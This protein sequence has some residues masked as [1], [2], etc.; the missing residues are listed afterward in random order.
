MRGLAMAILRGFP[1]T[2]S[3]TP[4]ILILGSFPSILS[5]ESGQY[6]GNPRN[7]FWP[8]ITALGA[9]LEGQ[10]HPLPVP[11]DYP[12]RLGILEKAGIALW[13]V[14]ASCEREG[15]LDE[16]IREELPNDIPAFLASRPGIEV[17]ALNGGRAARSFR[18]HFAPSV[19]RLALGQ[20]TEWKP[21]VLGGRRFVLLRLPS[22]SP[23]PTRDYRSSGDKLALWEGLFT[24]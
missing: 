10:D 6:Y 11:E 9:L 4:R 22:S 8:L 16:A 19:K 5:L 13:D 14:L 18:T 21:G 7:H 3:R 23:I 1:P 24:I 20:S 15:S 17:I 2:G 12:G